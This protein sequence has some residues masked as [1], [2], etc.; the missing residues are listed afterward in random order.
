MGSLIINQMLTDGSLQ[1]HLEETLIPTYRQ[2]YYAMINAIKVSLYPL[3]VRISNTGATDALAGGFF[4]Y[5]LFP[6]DGPSVADIARVALDEYQLRIAPGALFS[7]EKGKST[8]DK[9]YQLFLRGA[10]LCWAWQEEQELVEGIERLADAF[11][12]AKLR[13]D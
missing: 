2:R 6:D 3:G 12:Q 8:S 7:V 9:Q 4:L 5:I 11:S 10:R 13:Q 1:Q